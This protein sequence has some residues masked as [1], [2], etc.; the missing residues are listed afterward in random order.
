MLESTSVAAVSVIQRPVKFSAFRMRRRRAMAAATAVALAGVLGQRAGATTSNATWTDT[1]GDSLW[2]TATNWSPSGVPG[3]GTN[4]FSD[5]NVSIG[6][7][8]PCI[9]TIS[10]TIDN[11][12]MTTGGVLDIQAY[13]TLTLNGPALTDNGSIVIN[14]NQLGAQAGLDFNASTAVTGSGTIFLQQPGS[15]ALLSS[16]AGATVTQAATHTIAGYGQISAVLVNNG[17]VN[18][19][20]SGQ[21]LTVTSYNVSNNLT[22]EATN[23]G[24]LTI[25]GIVLTQG[26]AG[27]ITAAN[28]SSVTLT[29]ANVTG[30]SLVSSGSGSIQIN[31][32]S[33]IGSLTNSAVIDIP[34][35]TG[36]N[37]NGNLTDNG[38]IVVNN[39][40]VGAE[41]LL[42]FSGGTL[43]GTGTV[44]L[45]QA[46]NAVLSGSLTQSAGHTIAGY[47]EISAALVNN[48][49][50][51][52]NVSGGSLS[53]T[54]YN[55]SNNL[56]FQATN[57]GNLTI[58][59][60]LVT[61]GTSGQISAA[62]T[63]SVT[64]TNANVT[65]GS[66]SS[67]GNGSIQIN[68]T[69]TIGALTSSALIDIPINSA[70]NVSG[71]LT[72]NGSIVVNTTQQ[73]DLA[74][75][76]FSGGTLSGTG[77][78]LLQQGGNALLSGSL[79]QSATHSI[80]GYGM[81]GAA[82]TNNGTVNA[83]TSAG[84]LTL[85]TS[86][87]TNTSLMEATN[88]GTLNVNG[89]TLTQTGVGQLLA[90]NG[91]S[92]AISNGMISGGTLNTAGSGS[93][94]IGG[95]STLSSVTSNALINIPYGNQL[96]ISGN[97]VNS[98]V[99]V[100]NPTQSGAAAVLNVGGGTISGT[101]SILLFSYAG[102]AQ[103]NGSF[104]QASGHTI[105][106]YGEINAAFT[107][108]GV[109]T[110]NI[111]NG[112]LYIESP[113]VRNAN[114]MEA[115]GG[116]SL[117]FNNATAVNNSG[118]T[119]NA[120]GGNVVL[121]DGTSINSGTLSATAP[122]VLTLNNYN[123]T[124]G[125][126]ASLNNATL[127]TGT[128]LDIPYYQLLAIT[129]T[130]LT[131]N[132]K[133]VVNSNTGGA[134]A[135]LLFESNT[136]LTGSGTIQLQQ[137]GDNAIIA[138]AAG[139]TVT[140]DI[141]H[142]I[143]GFG[144]ITV[145]FINNNIVNANVSGQALN[146]TTSNMSN[147]AMFEATNGGVLAISGIVV[148]QSATAQILAADGSSVSIS[149][150]NISGGILN[151]AG[152]GS[153]SIAGTV[154]FTSLTNNAVVNLPYNQVLNVAGNLVDNGSIYVDSNTGGAVAELNFSGGTLSGTGKIYL[155]Q[156]GNNAQL[157]GSLT[158]GAGHSIIGFGQINAALINNGIINSNVS[159]QTLTIAGPVTNNNL[160]EATSGGSLNFTGTTITQ[161]SPAAIN[162][163]S[164]TVSYISNSNIAGGT[165]NGGGAFNISGTS[166]FT[167]GVVNNS[168]I[169][170]PYNQQLNITGGLTDNGSIVVDNN[171][172]G[173]VAELNFSG[174]TLSGTGTVY[175]EQAGNNAQIDGSFTQAAGHTIAG[176][177]QINA[178]MT[179]NGTINSNINGGVITL[180]SPLTNNSLIEASFNG[181]GLVISGVTIT[182]GA[183]G[184]ILAVNGSN[185]ALNN[186][187]V[188][189]GSIVG[190]GT[191]TVSG[192]A[193]LSN[194]NT[195][196]TILIPYNQ[197][198]N[199]V[200]TI[201]DTGQI[202]VNSNTGGAV[203]EL[204]FSGGSINGSGT[205][206]LQQGGQN[207]QVDGPFTQGTGHT[208]QGFGN[209]N[210]NFNNSGNV[211]A[212]VNGQ[213]LS[214]LGTSTNSG[215]FQASNGG[216]L[217]I[218]PGLLT[219]LAG[220]TITGG[221]YEADA[222][223]TISLSG[224]IVTNAAAIIL[225]GANYS[226]S[227]V[228]PLAANSGTF[229][230]KSG[231]VFSTVGNLSNSGGV[232]NNG[233]LTIN[234]SYNQTAGTTVDTGTMVVTGA[235]NISGGTASIGY[236][237][238]FTGSPILVASGAQLT[239]DGSLL[240]NPTVT[241][242]GIV[243][244]GANAGSGI[245]KRT[246][247]SLSI[248]SSGKATVST[249]GS[250]ATRTLLTTPLTIAGATNAWTG[251]LDL[252]DNDLDV[253]GGSLATITNQIK[254]G[255]NGGNW[256]G[257]GGIISSS[258]AINTTHLTTLGIIQNNQGGSALF[259]ASNPFDGT[260]PGA[261]DILVKYT[262]IGD[263]NLDG[264]VDGSDY[265]RID[266][267]Y[268]NH[269]TG[270]YNGDFNYDG[271]INGSDYT[272]IDNAFNTQGASLAA[273][274][275]AADAVATAQISA[276]ASVPEPGAVGVLGF[277]AIGL[278][279]RRGRDC[280]VASA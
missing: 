80:I 35:Y 167:G 153:F 10:P 57:G 29:N 168:T 87:M 179:N 134:V 106:G 67:A 203:A 228:A 65:G 118:G 32:T 148:T 70:L 211:N 44:L 169:D 68:G 137:P 250:A 138:G 159:G 246:L 132:G 234:G 198:L 249:S 81:I 42:N 66:L 92:V 268:L 165:L 183:A 227:A 18:A 130:T 258:A 231:A 170:I 103:L 75:L 52:A 215:Y 202:I 225:G 242:N 193:T 59:G 58:S 222:N 185:I 104:N 94:Q 115:T 184:E 114:L 128:E 279:R 142:G 34:A 230:L 277:A 113:T 122:N 260:T 89:I 240:S 121:A 83:N 60:I 13:N 274:V 243:T 256:Q 72:D 88:G 74:T 189:G 39:G 199:L 161:N 64:L 109:I 244:F 79:T 6:T 162:G 9:L 154:G 139:V 235:T 73:G 85:Q 151:G 28:T 155:E 259:T 97:L 93:F 111:S 43:S 102:N 219:N 207:A 206:T 267:G 84:T 63:S 147:N 278:L 124:A 252:T 36:L 253:P 270:W 90:A 61:Q 271:T 205:I 276:D 160:I 152:S 272:L 46:N 212:N 91:S 275:S 217:Y 117:Y 47:G 135:E 214:L 186:G 150:A 123:S 112:T 213:T 266:N 71:N 157:D 181:S 110:A 164:G 175:L 204:N 55:A 19:N 158:Q 232:N 177:G 24:N 54:G 224:N 62:N 25:N 188:S 182:Q 254:Q 223:S 15:N 82:L 129:G 218:S 11:L 208:I 174:G 178:V 126:D 269:L 27:R 149:S 125:D 108:G 173:A 78:V 133:I 261:G 216:I 248:G 136:L 12:T 197:Q 51:N 37:V 116:G 241:D 163:S 30:G 238:T 180:A 49:V 50:V 105:G 96:N 245:L 200:G 77:S 40:Q 172:G 190:P 146:L 145:P 156:G 127:T 101:G 220:T 280:A 255:Y 239:A 76:N 262:Y 107:N 209:V 196:A 16:A 2:S 4:G 38:T 53:V 233:S 210:G 22:F 98:G 166:A 201:N 265:N 31:G 237:G 187:N 5:Y 21:T 221:T 176:Y 48:G 171:T 192:T 144:A 263:A 264:K 229:V 20:S 251:K 140:Q 17:T 131:N 14:S 45:Q 257:S 273:T 195:S 1:A 23:G 100:V 119:I 141:H 99:V 3:N 86:A 236:G 226:F 191:A 95:T 7:P 8:S 69:S 143:Y 41:A 247:A 26:T 120:L 194:L 56:T 33:T